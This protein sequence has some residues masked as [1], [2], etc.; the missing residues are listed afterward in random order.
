MTEVA[1]IRRAN[2]VDV[3]VGGRVRERRILIG[4]T[5]SK[6]GEALGLTF[7]QIQKYEKGTNRIGASRLYELA[8]ILDVSVLHFFDGLAVAASKVGVETSA[9]QKQGHLIDILA[10]P[11]GV[12]FN[13]AFLN[14]DRA[15]SRRAI[16][17]LVRSL[18]AVRK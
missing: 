10:S 6:L 16:L 18:A 9:T 15:K 5:Q 17:N 1:S 2:P 8:R 3:H 12:E 4:M 7:Q 14:V 13:R 11:D